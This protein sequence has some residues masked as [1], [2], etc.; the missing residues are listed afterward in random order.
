[1]SEFALDR[2]ADALLA[3]VLVVSIAALVLAIRAIG[4]PR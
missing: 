3:S 2:I 4:R 1:M